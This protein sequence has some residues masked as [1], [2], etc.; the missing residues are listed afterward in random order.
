MNIFR[1]LGLYARTLRYVRPIQILWRLYMRAIRPPLHRG[2]I[3]PVRGQ[4]APLVR[5]RDRPV[6]LLGPKTFR[7][8]NEVFS[9]H[10]PSDWNARSASKLFLY[11]LHY[12]D[13]L[14]ARENK[15]RLG[16]HTALIRQWIAENPP[17]QGVGWEPYPL[18]LRVVNWVKWCLHTGVLDQEALESLVLQLRWLRRRLEFHLLGNHL[19]ANAK[20]L[21]FGGL[22]FDGPEPLQWQKK[23][24]QILNSELGEQILSDG[25]HFERSPMYHMVV[26]EDILDLINL[27]NVY[28]HS[29][30]DAWFDVVHRM[31]SWAGI[32]CHPDGEIPF[33]NDAAFGVAGTY[34]ELVS[35]AERL[36]I[37]IPSVG[38]SWWLQES[39]YARLL[40]DDAVLFFD[41]APVGPDYLP[42]HAHAD[43]LSIELSLFGK[44]ILVNSG[45]ST[46]GTGSERQRQ[47]GT[48]AHNT[49]TIDGQDSSEVWGGFRVGRRAR[50][51]SATCSPESREAF[52]EHDGYTRLPGSPVHRRRVKL[53]DDALVVEDEVEGKRQHRVKIVWH[54]HPEISV[55]ES[56]PAAGKSLLLEAPCEGG[57]RKVLFSV[58][59][60]VVGTVERSTWHPEFGKSIPSRRLVFEWEGELPL[61]V[62]SKVTW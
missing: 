11:N 53:S 61:R 35:Y 24:M 58:H 7:F 33:F 43:T 5:G 16:W 55:R 17:R 59:G 19:L 51:R 29:I 54:L 6:S 34:E 2:A 48:E 9:I 56:G 1:L 12:F 20:A 41:V 49:V 28:G 26:L 15:S 27:F 36:G 47:R 57:P 62:T 4:R 21:I 13:D 10:A 32:M 25:G 39:G 42:G 3:P 44:R 23:G 18:S 50:V 31:F 60:P 38:G 14:N 45:T 22:F 8:L 52:G 40:S 37:P 30:P 46:Y